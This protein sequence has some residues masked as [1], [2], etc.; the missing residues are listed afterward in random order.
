MLDESTQKASQDFQAKVDLDDPVSDDFYYE[1]WKKTATSN[2]RIFEEVFR[3]Y[4]TD[5]VNVV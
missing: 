1:I 5:L 3:C 2:T 4:P